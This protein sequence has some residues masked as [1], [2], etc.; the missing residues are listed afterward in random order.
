[1][2]AY[3]FGNLLL[4]HQKK[5]HHLGPIIYQSSKYIEHMIESQFLK[6]YKDVLFLRIDRK[7]TTD[8]RCYT[9]TIFLKNSLISR[10][11]FLSSEFVFA[12]IRRCFKHRMNSIDNVMLHY[13]QDVKFLLEVSAK[14]PW[15]RFACWWS[16][17]N[18]KL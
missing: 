4:L 5:I 14:W 1:M 6:I 8:C 15:D 11:L 2:F 3:K 18:G 16:K 7:P 17:M 13:E 12:K 10:W 9:V